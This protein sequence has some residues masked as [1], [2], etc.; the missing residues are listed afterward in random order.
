MSLTTAGIYCTISP[1]LS[2]AMEDRSIVRVQ[3]LQMLYRRRCCMSESQQRM[4]GI[5]PSPG[6]ASSYIA[7]N[8]M[9]ECN[10]LVCRTWVFTKS[11]LC[12][13]PRL[14]TGAITFQQRTFHQWP[15][16]S[17]IKP[18]QGYT[19]QLL[20][21]LA[22]AIIRGKVVENIAISAAAGDDDLFIAFMSS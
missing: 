20:G 13:W 22:D 18:R 6:Q 7:F 2:G 14:T 16:M 21:D 11:A 9:I 8:R 3:Q 19:S 1:P 5:P 17:S 15:Y 4:F 10:R 12:N